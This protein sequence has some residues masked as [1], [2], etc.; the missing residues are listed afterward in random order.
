MSS[1]FA[2]TLIGAEVIEQLLKLGRAAGMNKPGFGGT[3]MSKL[4]G[5]RF[6]NII[7]KDGVF[8]AGASGMAMG[9]SAGKVTGKVAKTLWEKG[10]IAGAWGKAKGTAAWQAF[11]GS[12]GMQRSAI[13]G[14]A[15]ALGYAT[16][17]SDASTGQRL[18]RAA[19]FGLLGGYGNRMA[20]D[21]GVRAGVSEGLI[22]MGNKQYKSGFKQIVTSLGGPQKWGIGHSIAAGAFYGALSS[23]TTVLGGATMG[24]AFDI[25]GRGLGRTFNK[26]SRNRI[27]AGWKSAGPLG[28]F[29]EVSLMKTGL[30]A[31]M[32][33]GA[34]NSG[35]SILGTA[36][37]ALKGT[38]A[39]G[40][41]RFATSHP[42]IT[43][44]TVVPG[45]Q[46]TGAVAQGVNQMMQTGSPGFDT[47]NADGDLALALHKM[48]HG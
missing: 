31:G 43:L 35:G 5:I 18:G 46:V 13:V 21:P 16:S 37:G 26:D 20:R 30:Y 40:A 23:D 45:M 1:A 6:A 25:G 36:G 7:E 28:A 41:A 39:G 17:N 12:P 24:A 38:A 14:G 3:I 34:Y 47:M 8:P 11:K 15:A 33:S 42:W 32:I 29:K 2:T 27:S 9:S 19:A 22:G 10:G 48:R 44:G 4:R